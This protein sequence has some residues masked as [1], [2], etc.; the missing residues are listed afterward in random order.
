MSTDSAVG[1]RY[2][3]HPE[4]GSTVRLFVRERKKS[5]RNL[6]APR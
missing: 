4:R 3:H 5:D 6:G 1:L 2:I